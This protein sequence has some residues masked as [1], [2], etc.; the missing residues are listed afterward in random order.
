MDSFV[1]A[2]FEWLSMLARS[3]LIEDI[4]AQKKKDGLFDYIDQKNEDSYWDDD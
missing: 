4:I 1:R 3:C 2:E